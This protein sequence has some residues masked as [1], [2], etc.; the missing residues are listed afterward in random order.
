MQDVITI[1]NLFNALR[2]MKGL[3]VYHYKDQAYPTLTAAIEALMIDFPMAGDDELT[4][5][6]DLYIEED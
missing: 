5:L 1:A 3:P 6:S 4:D 2:T